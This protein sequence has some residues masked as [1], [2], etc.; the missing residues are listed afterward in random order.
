MSLLQANT[1]D[2]LLSDLELACQDP[3]PA[4]PEP[5]KKPGRGPATALP[6]KSAQP[7]VPS[8]LV[9]K[10]T[11]D[12]Q[13]SGQFPLEDDLSVTKGLSLAS[14]AKHCPPPV[15]Q[16]DLS[17]VMATTAGINKAGDNSR[18]ANNLNELDVLLQDLSNARLGGGERNN[19]MEQRSESVM[20]S[21]SQVSYQSSGFYPSDHNRPL[22][23]ERKSPMPAAGVTRNPIEDAM[24]REMESK[25]ESRHEFVSQSSEISNEESKWQ[26]V[27]NGLWE[28]GDRQSS[29][30]P[31]KSPTVTTP[32]TPSFH[33]KKKQVD[34]LNLATSYHGSS[35]H[36]ASSAT[37]ELDD[38]MQSLN[39]FKLK[40]Q[41]EEPV[42]TNLD[43]M[44]GNLQ[45][46]MEKQG[47]K[48]TQ[49]G[50]C[51]ACNKPIVGQVVTALGKTFHPE[52][53]T[54]DHCNME[55]GTENFFER[56]GK[57]FCENDYHTLFSPRCDHCNGA[58]LDKCVSALDRTWHPEHF[59][60]YDCNSPFGDDGFHEKD[61]QA[62]C[63][64][65]YYGAFAPKCAG[66]SLA[67]TENFISSLDAQWHQNC[68][69]CATCNQ[70]FAD[71]NFF[72]HEGAPYCETHFHAL[73]GSLCAGCSKPISGRCITAMFRKF[74]PEHFVC[75]FCLKQLNKGTFKEKGE[76]P[77][78]H[79]CFNRLY[80]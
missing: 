14:E 15:P 4:R 46:N 76:K 75:S 16:R 67:I 8:H 58:I 52:H 2:G 78:C 28:N 60:C 30:E 29:Q 10:T 7:V 21:S 53:F 6:T 74:H 37:Q 68:F 24:I 64:N 72:E 33:E 5:P 26:Y 32:A 48:T 42:S 3:A 59:V 50:V 40:D 49:K 65:C 43:D 27:G 39:T 38:L 80:G 70:P 44:L 12:R 18:V 1:L 79:E 57:P 20:T 9:S 61:G 13:L 25:M 22:S 66:C 62:Y 54:C 71:G 17:S 31:T 11:S 35:R 47:V 23:A 19:M 34:T 41:K 36:K 56:E 73:K 55:L 45:E 63:K 51:G 77:Y 69:V